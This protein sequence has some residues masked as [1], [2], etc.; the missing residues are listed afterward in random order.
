MNLSSMSEIKEYIKMLTNENEDL[1]IQRNNLEKEIPIFIYSKKRKLMKQKLDLL[2]MKILDNKIRIE[3]Y[4]NLITKYSKFNSSDLLPFLVNYL[5]S[6]KQEEYVCIKRE[7]NYFLLFDCY[8]NIIT[9][10]NNIEEINNLEK[11]Y[12]ESTLDL[13]DELNNSDYICLEAEEEYSLLDGF[14]LSEYFEYYPC[15]KEAAY[16]LVDLKLE[17]SSITDKERL[18]I[19]I[20]NI[21]SKKKVKE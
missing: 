10:T 17:N 12:G 13:L 20:K 16:R 11:S 5:S 21:N 7:D 1:N 2:N 4:M 3:Q 19:I 15:L 14:D 6:V 18:D 9:T 8:Y